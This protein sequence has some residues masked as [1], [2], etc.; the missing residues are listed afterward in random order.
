MIIEETV[1]STSSV[2]MEDLSLLGLNTGTSA[3]SCDPCVA[4]VEWRA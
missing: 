2:K 4:L 3:T 1:N